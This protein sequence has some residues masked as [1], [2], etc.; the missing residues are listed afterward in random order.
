MVTNSAIRQVE[1]SYKR[2]VNG[3]QVVG[4]SNPPTPT[5][6]K[7]LIKCFAAIQ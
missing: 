3:V 5:M 2:K 6:A 4:G 7:P 1:N